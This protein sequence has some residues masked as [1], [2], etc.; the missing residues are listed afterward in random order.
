MQRRGSISIPFALSLTVI[1]A[2]AAISVD[3]GLTRYHRQELGNA[4]EAAAH[5]GAAQLDGT[6]AGLVAARATAVALGAENLVGGRSVALDPNESNDAEGDVVLGYWEG[7]HLEPSMEPALVTAVQVVA[8]REDLS[9]FF[10]QVVFGREYLSAGDYAI[11][12]SGGP[13]EAECPLPIALADCEFA[14]IVAGGCSTDILLTSA[15]IDNG[16]WGQPGSTTPNANYIRDALDRAS[17]AAAGE[18]GQQVTLNNGSV[19]SAIQ[20]LAA[21]V[22]AST[23]TWD[24]ATWGT[25]PAAMSGSAISPYGHVLAGQVMVFDDPGNCANI[26]YTG[27]HEIVAYAQAVVYDVVTTTSDKRFR[28]RIVCEETDAQG[29]GAYFG[30]TVPPKFVR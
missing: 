1:L 8:H 3:L 7:D 28:L 9:S 29:G 24:S 30:T 4:A 6:E 10:A 14:A 2:F 27:N 5:A 12:Q 20:K 22:N 17:C 18:T 11:S 21:A 16:A 19:T 15:R 25:Q 23:D 13:S 26:Q